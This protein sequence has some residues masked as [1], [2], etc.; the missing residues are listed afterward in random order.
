M[1]AIQSLGWE[2]DRPNRIKE[3]P[4]E[5]YNVK[6]WVYNKQVLKRSLNNILPMSQGD[7]A[8]FIHIHL[9]YI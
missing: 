3:S 5:V 4:D 1:V 8:D 6:E 2:Y 7:L 9:G